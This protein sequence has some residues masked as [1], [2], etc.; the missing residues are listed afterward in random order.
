MKNFCQILLGFMLILVLG[1]PMGLLSAQSISVGTV[2]NNQGVVTNVAGATQ[3]LKGGLSSSATIS[4]LRIE[5]VGDEE[6]KFYLLGQVSGDLVSAK[7]IELQR[8]G[9]ELRAVGGP[10]VEITCIGKDCSRCDIKM[11][12]MKFYC[13][14][15]ENSNPPKVGFCDMTSK[16]IVTAW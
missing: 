7:G 3:A 14:C 11:R 5:W 2:Q 9:D 6:N 1:P 8:F 12:K 15:E 13:V 10:G 4:N 16:F